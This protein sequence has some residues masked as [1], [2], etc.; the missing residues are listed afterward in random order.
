MT[1]S[2]STSRRTAIRQEDDLKDHKDRILSLERSRQN[3]DEFGDRASKIVALEDRLKEQ[4][5]RN[6]SLERDARAS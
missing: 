4:V 5:D 1:H 2:S 6:L 3:A